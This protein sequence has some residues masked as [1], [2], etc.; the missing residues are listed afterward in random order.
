MAK[1]GSDEWKRNIAKGNLGK[2]A[3]NKG[4]NKSDPR[5]AIYASKIKGRI[6]SL[7]TRKKLSDSRKGKVPWNK[8][9]SWSPEM[10]EKIGRSL[11]G[12]E[13]LKAI[14]GEIHYNWQHKNVTYGAVHQWMRR[15]FGKASKCE[16][17]KTE[18]SYRYEWANKTGLYKRDRSDWIELCKSCHNTYDGIIENIPKMKGKRKPLQKNNNAVA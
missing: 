16:F 8:G 6:V 1:K 17:C 10:K 7:S 18:T 9:K 11:K 4:L 13:K 14:K 3:W 12:N 15:E 5:V 2:K